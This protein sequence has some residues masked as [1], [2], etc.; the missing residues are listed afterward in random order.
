[1]RFTRLE[2]LM[3][4][5]TKD[6]DRLPVIVW[7]LQHGAN[8]DFFSLHLH[9]TPCCKANMPNN[10]LWRLGHVSIMVD[11]PLWTKL[12]SDLVKYAAGVC[13]AMETDHCVCYCSSDGCLPLH[14]YLLLD[15]PWNELCQGQEHEGN[16]MISW[17]VACNP[18]NYEQTQC[19]EEAVRMELFFRL[20]L[21]H[22]CCQTWE[23]TM[24]ERKRIREEYEELGSQ[25]SLLM[26]AYRGSL[27]AFL[28]QE[29]KEFSTAFNCDCMKAKGYGPVTWG[30]HNLGRH[31]TRLLAHWRHWW[32]LVDQVLVDPT[33]IP[34]EYG[35][36]YNI[37]DTRRTTADK[38][39][40][41]RLEE[42][43]F[44]GLDYKE[45][46]QRHFARELQHSTKNNMSGDQHNRREVKPMVRVERRELLDGLM[47]KLRR[48]AS[49]VDEGKEGSYLTSGKRKECDRPHVWVE[50][51]NRCHHSW[52]YKT[53]TPRSDPQKDGARPAVRVALSKDASERPENPTVSLMVEM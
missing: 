30:S 46:I 42:R 36:R 13:S 7:L 35:E 6:L 10:L 1:M 40:A 24:E 22:T 53:Q 34:L 41:L 32:S 33:A 49:G 28:Q 48:I 11:Y 37:G 23:M 52:D 12:L 45:V 31:T 50:T 9:G 18:E 21:V 17:I 43:G 27:E 25:L 4:A 47:K 29:E 19:F 15:R 3:S 2:G 51:L 44:G 38:M 5:I 20:G 8:P 39:T 26:T 16:M 14:R